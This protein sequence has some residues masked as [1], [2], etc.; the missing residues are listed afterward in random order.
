V[1]IGHG[2]H[3]GGGAGMTGGGNEQQFMKAV[4]LILARIRMLEKQIERQNRQS[5]NGIFGMGNGLSN[6][7]VYEHMF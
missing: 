1:D 3:T 6:Y 5:N 7:M 4:R 2:G